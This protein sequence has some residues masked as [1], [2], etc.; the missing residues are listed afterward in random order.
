MPRTGEAGFLAKK[1][2]SG[3]GVRARKKKRLLTQNRLIEQAVEV[4]VAPL[5]AH[6][7]GIGSHDG[8]GGATRGSG[9]ASTQYVF[10]TA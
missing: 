1:P 5:D 2:A 4:L 10:G 8:Y 3:P 9:R 6:R 7:D